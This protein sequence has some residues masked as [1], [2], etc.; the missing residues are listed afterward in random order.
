MIYG[1][2]TDPHFTLPWPSASY[3][4]ISSVPPAPRDHVYG[5]VLG[6]RSENVTPPPQGRQ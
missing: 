5:Y 2:N 3:T 6:G 4:N 1:S